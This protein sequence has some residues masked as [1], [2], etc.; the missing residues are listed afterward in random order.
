MEAK[1]P[2][3]LTLIVVAKPQQWFLAAVDLRGHVHRLLCSEPGDLA[4]Y[5][6]LPFDDQ[7]SFLRH[8]ICGVL[9]RGHDRLWPVDRKACQFVFLFAGDLPGTDAELIPRLADHFAEWMLSPP[10]VVFTLEHG[11]NAKVTEIRQ[12]AGSMDSRYRNALTEAFPSLLHAA[13]D[14]ASWEI[15]SHKRTWQPSSEEKQTTA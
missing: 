1:E 6:G 11:L 4:A 5:E 3:I 7:M 14:P 2:M 8:R 12:L 15:S 13:T 9:Q 10:A